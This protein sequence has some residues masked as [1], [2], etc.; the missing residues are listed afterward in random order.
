[1]VKLQLELIIKWADLLIATK[2]V[3]EMGVGVGGLAICM[4]S[5]QTLVIG[6][7]CLDWASIVTW[8]SRTQGMY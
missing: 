7:P 8:E 6:I 5:L 1:M 3:E 2:K 4:F